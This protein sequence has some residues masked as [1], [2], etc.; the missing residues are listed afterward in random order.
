M[1]HGWSSLR[2][3]QPARYNGDTQRA[4]LKGQ[5]KLDRQEEKT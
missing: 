3:A 5:V 2:R 1:E 4:P